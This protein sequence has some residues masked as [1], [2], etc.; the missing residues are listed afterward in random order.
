MRKVLI[1][2]EIGF[3]GS[4]LSES[5]LKRGYEVIAI[6]DLST[7]KFEN[8]EHLTN[9][10]KF[11]FAIETIMNEGVMDRLISECDM[12]YHLAVDRIVNILAE[13]KL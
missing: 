7:G 5:L 8:I 4:H 2:A 11:H 9:N 12:L 10:P 6:D 1:T 3:I 13:S